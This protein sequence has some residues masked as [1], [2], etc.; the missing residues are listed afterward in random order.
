MACGSIV[1][2]GRVVALFCMLAGALALTGCGGSQA[3][4]AGHLERGRQY[5]E[6]GNYQKGGVEFRNALQIDPRNVEARVL[7]G[8]VAEQGGDF[9]A[10]VTAY[11]AALSVD[12]SSATARAALARIMVFAGEPAQALEMV[13]PGRLKAPHDADLLTVRGAARL[14]QKDMQAAAADAE[15]AHQVAPQN[16]NAIA[17]LAAIYRQQSDLPRAEALL[18]E[19]IDKNPKSV[20]LREV[21][22]NLYSVAGD[23]DKAEQQMRKVIEL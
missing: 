11:R 8:K 15:A 19:A 23:A 18:V 17:L 6:Q 5:L 2:R 4:L 22:A 12:E 21:L 1:R 14:V 13:E 3:R 9:R 7:S 16:E 10:A 20:D